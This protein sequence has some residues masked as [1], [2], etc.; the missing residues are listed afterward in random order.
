MMPFR[1]G[2]IGGEGSSRIYWRIL[3]LD[4]FGDAT[5]IA[6]GD[7]QMRGSPG[8]ASILTG[9][10]ASVSDLSA[11]GTVALA[12]DGSFASLWFADSGPTNQWFQYQF[13]SSVEV[14]EIAIGQGTSVINPLTRMPK[15]GKLQKSSDGATWEDVFAFQVPGAFVIGKY[16][17]FPE[18]AA[19]AG[20]HR[21]WRLSLTGTSGGSELSEVE[22]RATSGGADQ[23]A[24]VPN[25]NGDA[26]GRA[27]YSSGGAG[28]EG[29]KLFDNNGGS[30][31]F[32]ASNNQWAGYVF[33]DPVKVEQLSVRGPV[34]SG[35][36]GGTGMLVQYSD[37]L[38]TW[39]TQKTITGL[40]WAVNETKIL[41]AI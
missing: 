25:G 13:P 26:T 32:S 2:L 10:T 12:Y 14:V 38:V 30:W 23:T 41:A 17:T 33:P 6:I 28:A 29:Y 24:A 3:E 35:A 27:I 16:Y 18:T 1:T 7:L 37:D 8:G 22:F 40:S 15:N 4:N 9:G 34:N 39:T 11:G 20:Y 5:G 21:A 36:R 31:W 19:A